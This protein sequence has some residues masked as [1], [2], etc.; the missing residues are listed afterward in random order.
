M[1]NIVPDRWTHSSDHFDTL[2][3]YCE[4]LLC[5]GKAYV[6]DTDAETMR[7][8]REEKKESRRRNA[9]SYS[10]FL[11]VC[12]AAP[13]ENL[14]LWEEMKKGSERGQQCAVRIKIDMSSNNGAL[15]DPTIYRC[16]NEPHVRTRDKYKYVANF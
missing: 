9:C 4:K 14:A 16:K 6:D 15:R 12:F 2:L 10:P 3:G 7:K 5:E 1:L 13:E 8:E 11:R